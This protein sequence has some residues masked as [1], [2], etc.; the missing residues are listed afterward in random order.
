MESTAPR[1]VDE[2]LK[3]G[4]ESLYDDL[5]VVSCFAANEL[6]RLLVGLDANL[7][8]V[9]RLVKMIDN[10]IP[11][12]EHAGCARSLADSNT[13]VA[14]AHALPRLAKDTQA[15]AEGA[16]EMTSLLSRVAQHGSDAP[17]TPDDLV[18]ARSFCLKL[19]KSVRS[20]D[21]PP[22]INEVLTHGR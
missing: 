16:K 8:I 15:V 1:E 7:S 21:Y 2:D 3:A 4:A 6:Q 9:V 19:A 11:K 10:W 5:A 17:P 18:K 14:M 12:I 13:V 20:M 22:D